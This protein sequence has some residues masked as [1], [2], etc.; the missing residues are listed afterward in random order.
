MSDGPDARSF[1][2][3]ERGA[4]D[5]RVGDDLD[6][7]AALTSGLDLLRGRVR[8]HAYMHDVAYR[9]RGSEA[10]AGDDRHVSG[11]AGERSPR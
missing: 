10:R 5:R 9:L 6:P 11:R 4:H 7:R 3:R 2:T 1:D 8:E